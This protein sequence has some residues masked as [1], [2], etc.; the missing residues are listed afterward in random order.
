MEEYL[1]ENELV[2]VFDNELIGRV[3]VKVMK[4]LLSGPDFIMNC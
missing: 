3:M 2:F 1:N 4:M